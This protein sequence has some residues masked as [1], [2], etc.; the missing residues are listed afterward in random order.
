[1]ENTFSQRREKQEK[2]EI[3]KHSWLCIDLETVYI[4]RYYTCEKIGDT[5]GNTFSLYMWYLEGCYPSYKEN[6]CEMTRSE[7]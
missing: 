7:I 6:F 1:M 2:L 4:K 5:S 3:N